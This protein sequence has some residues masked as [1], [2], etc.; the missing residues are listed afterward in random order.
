MASITFGSVGDIIS[1]CQV[2]VKTVSALSESRGSAVEYQGL[3]N[4]LW[5]LAQALESL[6]SLLDDETQLRHRGR[7]RL[8][9]QNCRECL[10]R[11]LGSLRKFSTSLSRQIA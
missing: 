10:E 5:S 8:A 11:E 1:I 9:L 2:I 4:E 3:I 7:L 6:K